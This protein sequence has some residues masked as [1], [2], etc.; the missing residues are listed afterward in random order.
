MRGIRDISR[1]SS[2]VSPSQAQGLNALGAA[3]AA[4]SA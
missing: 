4:P 2:R 1:C 3:N